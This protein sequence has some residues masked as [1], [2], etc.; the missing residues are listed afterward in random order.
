MLKRYWNRGVKQKIILIIIGLIVFSALFILRDDY[1]PFLL[2][3]RKYLFVLLLFVGIIYVGIRSFRKAATALKKVF[4]AILT[5]ASVAL[6]Y[7]LFWNVGMYDYMQTY[8]VFTNMNLQEISK[9]PL[10]RNE[11]IQPYNNIKTMAYETIT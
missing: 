10:S 11:R 8:N 6:I 5:L 3:L 4:K 7:V 2:F 1:Q 9:L